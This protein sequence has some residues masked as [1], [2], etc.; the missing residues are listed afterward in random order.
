MG[1]REVVAKSCEALAVAFEHGDTDS[2]AELYTDDA[3]LFVP[4]N[5]PSSHSLHLAA[6]RPLSVSK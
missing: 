5:M 3:E 1:A 2:I 6:L 4:G